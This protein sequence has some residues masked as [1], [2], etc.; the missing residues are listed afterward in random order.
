MGETP[1]AFHYDYF[2]LINGKLYYYNH[3]D[4][5]GPLMTKKGKRKLVGTIADI[6]AKERLLQIGF[7]IPKGPISPWEYVALNRLEEELPSASDL[8]KADEIDARAW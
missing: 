3:K 4:K 8:D 2:K 1:E 5:A 7:D 6:L